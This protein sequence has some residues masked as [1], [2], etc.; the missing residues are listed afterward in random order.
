MRSAAGSAVDELPGA[1]VDE[2]EVEACASRDAAGWSMG[3]YQRTRKADDPTQP[4]L[5]YLTVRL[6]DFGK[7]RL[8]YGRARGLL[9]SHR[10]GQ[11]LRDLPAIPW[12]KIP[13]RTNPATTTARLRDTRFNADEYLKFHR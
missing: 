4:R 5:V 12:T 1:G 9:W 7:D 6:D 13:A 10:L 8:K 11:G 2:H 3:R